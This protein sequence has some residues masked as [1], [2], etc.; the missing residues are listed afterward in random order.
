MP[1]ER[2]TESADQL[3]DRI[4]RAARLDPRLPNFSASELRLETVLIL[5]RRGHG[6]LMLIDGTETQ[7]SLVDLPRTS[8]H[9]QCLAYFQMSEIDRPIVVVDPVPVVSPLPKR[10]GRRVEQP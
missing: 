2:V 9:G 7:G 10:K 8:L 5:T 4:E 3:F 1:E 6:I